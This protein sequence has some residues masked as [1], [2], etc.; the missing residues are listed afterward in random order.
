ML[1]NLTDSPT[2]QALRHYAN[3]PIASELVR[4]RDTTIVLGR[5]D[6]WAHQ[7]SSTNAFAGLAGVSANIAD[8]DRIRDIAT[9]ISSFGTRAVADIGL[10]SGLVD[11]RLKVAALAGSADM[12]G[13]SAST[14]AAAYER[15]FGDWYTKPDLPDRFWRDLGYRRGYYADA[16]VD[17]GLMDTTPE[18]AV[19]VF[20]AEAQT[21][22]AGFDAAI[23]L[24]RS[25]AIYMLKNLLPLFLL[26]LVVFATLFFPET[27]FRE[28]VTI[29]VTAILTSAVLLLAVNNQIGDVGYTLVVEEI[30]YIFFG[31][32][33]MAI[34]AGYGHENFGTPAERASPFLW[35]TYRRSSMSE[36]CSLSLLCSTDVMPREASMDAS[37]AVIRYA[38]MHGT[39]H[40]PLAHGFVGATLGRLAIA[41]H[42]WSLR[43]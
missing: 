22:F 28:R 7:L 25:S 8:F 23:M 2:V 1:R 3:S 38:K 32:C 12:L 29:P 39:K 21:E 11:T 24:R 15:L 16:E 37:L 31:L 10:A 30:F 14:T 13:F 26:V 42:C 43:W 41:V 40:R 6:R 5:T 36:R 20:G 18:T 27:M 4:Y 9:H 35:I 33:L 19:A 34:L 17:A